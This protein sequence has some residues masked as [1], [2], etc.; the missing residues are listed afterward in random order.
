M[1]WCTIIWIAATCSNFKKIYAN[2]SKDP[3]QFFVMSTRS[4]TDAMGLNF[5][6]T[7]YPVI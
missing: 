1:E 5:L 3:L 6:L 7:L 2:V 4:T